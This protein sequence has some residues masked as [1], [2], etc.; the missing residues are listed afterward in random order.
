VKKAHDDSQTTT[1]VPSRACLRVCIAKS[2]G[3]EPQP[4]LTTI[5]EL[6]T[7]MRM[8]AGDDDGDLDGGGNNGQKPIIAVAAMLPATTSHAMCRS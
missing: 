5:M 7:R 3:L 6:G 8:A 1:V 2:K 4:G